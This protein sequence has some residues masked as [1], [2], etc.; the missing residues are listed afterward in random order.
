MK[1]AK[2]HGSNPRGSHAA[3]VESIPKGWGP[4]KMVALNSLRPRPENTAMIAKFKARDASAEASFHEAYPGEK[5]TPFPEDARYKVDAIRARIRNGE[6]LP[7]LAVNKDG[8]IEDGENRWNAYKAE[9]VK[10]I[11]VRIRQ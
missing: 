3:G 7:P 11:P 9:G 1:D 4:V 2:G 6:S 5:Y 8:S 10:K